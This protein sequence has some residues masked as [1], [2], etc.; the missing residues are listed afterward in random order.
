MKLKQRE[1]ER[2]KDRKKPE[3]KEKMRGRSKICFWPSLSNFPK[4]YLRRFLRDRHSTV[5]AQMID[6]QKSITINK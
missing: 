3:I 1:E 2:K 5:E 4:A 6:E